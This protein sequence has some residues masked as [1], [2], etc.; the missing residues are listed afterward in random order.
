MTAVRHGWLALRRHFLPDEIKF[1][2][3]WA[4][5]CNTLVAPAQAVCRANG[6]LRPLQLV[7]PQDLSSGAGLRLAVWLKGCCC[8]GLA[9]ASVG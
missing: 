1:G 7:P 2:G 4:A 9:P 3:R 5:A 8:A 6:L